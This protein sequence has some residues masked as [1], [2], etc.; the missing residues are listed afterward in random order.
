MIRATGPTVRPAPNGTPP[1]RRTAREQPAKSCA[2]RA[3]HVTGLTAALLE[4]ASYDAPGIHHPAG[5]D[6]LSRH[7]LGVLIAERDSLD[8]SRLPAGTRTDSGLH[9]ALDVR[10]D[11]RATRRKPRT[12]L[13]GAR[14]FCAE[15][16]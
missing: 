13:R 7:E 9:G 2:D 8:A 1:T 6:A 3:P 15:P 4:P 16:A 10:L 12:T 5:P 14:Q 11:S